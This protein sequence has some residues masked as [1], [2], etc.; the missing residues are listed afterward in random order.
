[1]LR[2]CLLYT[3]REVGY[4]FGQYKRIMGTFEGGT[5]TGKGIPFGGSCAL[6]LQRWGCLLY[7][8]SSPACAS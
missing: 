3:S 2:V 7:T 5:I 8:S 1:M 4:L 6:C